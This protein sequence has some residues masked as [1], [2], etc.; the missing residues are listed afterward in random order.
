MLLCAAPCFAQTFAVASLKP[1]ARP[2]GKD[3]RGRIA[4]Q[5]DRLSARNVSLTDLLVEAYGV[6]RFQIEG[7][8]WLDDDEFDIDARA[9][10]AASRAELRRMLQQLLAE[11]FDLGVR[12]EPRESRVFVLSAGKSGV[13][14]HPVS[15]DA[16]ASA[17]PRFHGD[18]RQF[19][20]LLSIQ[21]SIPANASDPSRP[22][23]AS[24]RPVPVVDET[25]LE[26]VYEF[27]VDL[28]P[29]LGSD[30]FVRWQRALQE[31]FGLKLERRQA[32]VEFVKVERATRTPRAN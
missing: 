21:L 29:E 28:P 14:L 11:R 8:S 20:N 24:G 23:I 22:S 9:D 2:A 19:A 1:S 13:K 32:P 30:P 16:P 12:R 27:K 17:W 7:P 15:S 10:N 25:G 18:M 5:P 26:G 6:Q 4:V 3:Y 31:Q